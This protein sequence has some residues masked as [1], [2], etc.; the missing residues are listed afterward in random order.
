[1]ATFSISLSSSVKHGI[2]GRDQDSPS[3]S[4]I[5]HHHH[6]LNNYSLVLNMAHRAGTGFSIFLYHHHHHYPPMSNMGLGFSIFL[7]HHHHHHYT[8]VSNMAH[9]AGTRILHLPLLSITTIVIFI[10]ILQCQTWHI[11]QGPG[12]SIFLCHHHH[13]HHHYPPES[14]MAPKVGIR[15]LHPSLFVTACSAAF[16][17]LLLTAFPS[18]WSFL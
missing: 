15:I 16:M 13:H 17:S 2:Q 12:V 1:M 11:G 6:H 14:N 7:Y 8:P 9:R 10:I 5:Y 3:S 18:D 4:M